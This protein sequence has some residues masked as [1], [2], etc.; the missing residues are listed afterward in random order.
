MRVCSV[1]DCGESMPDGRG[2]QGGL[3]MCNRC[4]GSVY[5]WRKLGP[6]ALAHYQETLAFRA[7]RADFVQPLV[8]R[9][10]KR[11]AARMSEARQRAAVH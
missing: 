5:R 4:I 1:P 7:G 11:A 6:K 10:L 2:S 9:I 8:G 3:E